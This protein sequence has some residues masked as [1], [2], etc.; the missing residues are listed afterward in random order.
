MGRNSG[1]LGGEDSVSGEDGTQAWGGTSWLNGSSLSPS[2]LSCVGAEGRGR[3][4][5]VSRPGRGGGPGRGSQR[6]PGGGAGG[7]CRMGG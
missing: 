7:C 3:R 1:R 5:R 2:F 4:S 6:E